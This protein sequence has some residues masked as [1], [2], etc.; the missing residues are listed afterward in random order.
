MVRTNHSWGKV[1]ASTTK[2]EVAPSLRSLQG[3]EAIAQINES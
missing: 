2:K 1:F 3:W